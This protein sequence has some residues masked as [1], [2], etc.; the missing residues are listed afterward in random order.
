MRRV[1]HKVVG[2]GGEQLP[3]KGVVQGGG[4]R[5]SSKGQCKM[6][7]EEGESLGGDLA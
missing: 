3:L 1:R 2:E 5:F 7:G 6:V 4:W